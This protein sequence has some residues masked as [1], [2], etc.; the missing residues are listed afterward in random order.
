VI[1][2]RIAVAEAWGQFGNS[3]ELPPLEAV[4]GRLVKT[5]TEDIGLSSCACV[6]V[7]CEVKSRIV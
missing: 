6:G 3:G 2:S 7:T 4:S 1:Q 5:V